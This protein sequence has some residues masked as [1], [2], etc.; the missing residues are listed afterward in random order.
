MDHWFTDK[1]SNYQYVYSCVGYRVYKEV[2]RCKPSHK[3]FGL[4]T[5]LFVWYLMSA[6]FNPPL[7][8]HDGWWKRDY[9]TGETAQQTLQ[10]HVESVFLSYKHMTK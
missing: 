4:S 6:E 10:W 9:Y 3:C 2:T 8:P 5:V 1:A 7:T